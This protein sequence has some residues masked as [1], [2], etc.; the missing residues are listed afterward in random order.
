MTGFTLRFVE[1]DIFP[2]YNMLTRS[3]LKGQTHLEDSPSVDYLV[4]E[5][6]KYLYFGPGPVVF[7]APSI[8]LAGRGTPT[9][10]VVVIL[11]SAAVVVFHKILACL[12]YG[13]KPARAERFIF[14]SL[15]ALNGFSL[16]MTAI[17]SIHHEAILSGMFFL[18]CGIYYVLRHIQEGAQVRVMGALGAG[19]CFL[20]AMLCRFSYCLSIVFL[21]SAFVAYACRETPAASRERTLSALS[22]LAAMIFAGLVVT[23]WYNYVRFGSPFDFGV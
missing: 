3:F 5:G 6:K 1:V 8:L 11:M 4:F 19:F 22:A 10:V 16:L 13:L 7:H 18:L 17:P 14:S 20:M 2:N 12:E 23:F 9:G 21:C 15:F